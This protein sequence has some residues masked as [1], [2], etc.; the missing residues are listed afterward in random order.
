MELQAL[1]ESSEV[2]TLVLIRGNVASLWTKRKNQRRPRV[3]VPMQEV[4]DIWSWGGGAGKELTSRKAH[5]VFPHPYEVQQGYRACTKEGFSFMALTLFA[6]AS[7]KKE[8]SVGSGAWLRHEE[9]PPLTTDEV[10]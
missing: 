1:R 9:Q 6:E 10:N 2:E 8:C 5:K 7:Y 3:E 4:A